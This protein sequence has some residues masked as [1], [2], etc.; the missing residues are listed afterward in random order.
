MFE[1]HRNDE[2]NGSGIT[3]DLEPTEQEQGT[4]QRILI[5]DDDVEQT[6]VLA[7]ALRQQGFE[8]VTAH[9]V[10]AGHTSAELLQP[11]LIIMDIRLP[12]GDGLQ[13]CQ[14]LSDDLQLCH[15]PKIVV[16]GMERAGIVRHARAAGCQFYLRKPY[17]PNALLLLAE[18]ALR[19][20]EG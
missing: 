8:V 20:G 2:H 18:N 1:T 12:D 15:I 11:H 9:S 7:Y 13:L 5:I 16:S 17:D 6:Q 14:Q 10:S 3:I 4:K 19:F